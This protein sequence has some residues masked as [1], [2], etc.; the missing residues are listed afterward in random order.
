MSVDSDR[1]AS[2]GMRVVEQAVLAVPTLLRR[3]ATCRRAGRL[4]WATCRLASLKCRARPLSAAMSGWLRAGAGPGDQADR[5]VSPVLV[6]LVAEAVVVDLRG[7]GGAVPAGVWGTDPNRKAR[8]IALQAYFVLR[9]MV[10]AERFERST[11]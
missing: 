1:P 8:R 2:S 7:V 9:L 10:G 5:L 4:R 3:V 6:Q 11:S